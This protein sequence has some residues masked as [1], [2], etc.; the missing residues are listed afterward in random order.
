MRRAAARSDG[1]LFIDFDRSEKRSVGVCGISE[2]LP[3]VPRRAQALA[4]LQLPVMRVIQEPIRTEHTS[5]NS[6]RWSASS[7]RSAQKPCRKS[8]GG[9]TIALQAND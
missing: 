3:A 5:D 9:A 7:G 6:D 4:A 2:V 8:A 1:T